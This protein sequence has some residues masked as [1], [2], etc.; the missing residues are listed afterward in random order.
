MDF[1][2]FWCVLEQLLENNIIC[3][4]WYLGVIFKVLKVLSDCFSGEIFDDQMV[5]SFFFLDEYFICFFLCFSCGVGCKNSMNYGKEGVFY[6]VKSCC[7]Y[8]YQYDN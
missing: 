3:F 8:F 2:G 4:F 1:F 6:E 5:Y 7:R